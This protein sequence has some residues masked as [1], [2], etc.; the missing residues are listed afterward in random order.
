MISCLK[1]ETIRGVW[2]I[3]TRRIE[4]R[5]EQTLL[6]VALPFQIDEHLSYGSSTC[7]FALSTLKTPGGDGYRARP[8]VLFATL[9]RNQNARGSGGDEGPKRGMSPFD[10]RLSAL[11]IPRS[12]TYT[13]FL[14][15]EMSADVRDIR[16]GGFPQTRRYTSRSAR[17]KN[18]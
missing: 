14:Y 4:C 1:H 8:A 7:L 11:S 6:D 2:K 16:H 17:Q 3:P 15:G 9:E 12:F 13:Q 10:I 5:T 18:S